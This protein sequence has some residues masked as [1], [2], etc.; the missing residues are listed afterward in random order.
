MFVLKSLLHFIWDCL[1]M[2]DQWVGLINQNLLSTF[3]YLYVFLV[4]I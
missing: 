4:E 1:E 3:F 2:W